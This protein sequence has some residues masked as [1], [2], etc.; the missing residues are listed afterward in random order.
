MRF[1][2]ITN[3]ILN[4]H[5]HDTYSLFLV[6]LQQNFHVTVYSTNVQSTKDHVFVFFFFF[7]FFSF[8]FLLVCL[9][10]HYGIYAI[11]SHGDTSFLGLCTCDVCLADTT[12]VL[13]PL[14]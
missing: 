1:L 5:T 3:C 13:Q 14:P 7:F 10:T 12:C 2:L 6:N 9:H 11:R 8:L 4:K